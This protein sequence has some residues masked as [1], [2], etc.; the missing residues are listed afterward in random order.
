MAKFMFIYRGGGEA[1]KHASPEEAQ[2]VMQLWMDWIEEADRAGWMLDGGDALKPEGAVV[3][4]DFSVTD[5]PFAESKELVGGYSQIEA[6]D[7][8]AAAELAKGCPGLKAGG[9]VEI[10][11]LANVGKA[12]G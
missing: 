5:G 2:Q 4:P 6:P 11:E 3:Q 9:T 12:D 1:L 8:K 7:L 10:R